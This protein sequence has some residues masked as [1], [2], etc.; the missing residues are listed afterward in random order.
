MFE[1]LHSDG[2]VRGVTGGP[3]ADRREKIMKM[4][5][6]LEELHRTF[7]STLGSRITFMTRG[8][9]REHANTHTHTHTKREASNQSQVLTKGS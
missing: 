4:L 8:E 6:A 9:T 5:S 3:D 1:G 7:N 2:R